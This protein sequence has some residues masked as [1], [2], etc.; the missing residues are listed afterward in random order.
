MRAITWTGSCIPLFIMDVINYI[1][2]KLNHHSGSKMIAILNDVK[3]NGFGATFMRIF[4]QQL[5]AFQIYLV[6]KVCK[7]RFNDD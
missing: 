6:H 2:F 1:N 5:F 4:P 7:I 3:K